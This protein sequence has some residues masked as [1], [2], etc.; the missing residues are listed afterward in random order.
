M[1]R[2]SI[3][4]RNEQQL[5]SAGQAV[6]DKLS[7]HGFPLIQRM[8][9][10]Q[11]SENGTQISQIWQMD[12]DSYKKLFENLLLLS[13]LPDKKTPEKPAAI[14]TLPSIRSSESDVW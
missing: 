14:H 9:T 11:V 4:T 5:R 13:C 1:Y 6:P 3:L 10:D 7:C 12:T 2:R 8:I